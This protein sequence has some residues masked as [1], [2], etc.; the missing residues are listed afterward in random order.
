MDE[1]AIQRIIQKNNEQLLAQMSSLI[2]TTVQGLKRSNDDQAQEQLQEIK[3]LKY[4][5]IPSFK[6]KS[7]EDQFKSTN[8]VMMCLDDATDFLSKKDLDKTKEA[9]DKG[10]VLLTER[11]KLIKLADKSPFGW[12]TV[13]EYKQ[14]DLAADEEDEKK[15]YRAEARAAREVK[16]FSSTQFKRQGNYLCTADTPN[17]NLQLNASIP[18]KNARPLYKMPYRASGVCFSCGKPGH[19]RATCPLLLASNSKQDK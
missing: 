7:N 11:Q 2:S 1:A 14:H 3:K 19:W 12:K 10:R 18:F 16:K 13:L 5:D 6:T 8:A 17:S 4:A 9:I 15:I